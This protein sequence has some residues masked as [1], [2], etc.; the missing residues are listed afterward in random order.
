[1]VSASRPL[2]ATAADQALLVGRGDALDQV[3]NAVAAG[4]NVL[5]DSAPGGGRT[6]LVNA[7][8]FEST[9]A[10]VVRGGGA[11][12]SN[13]LA[14]CITAFSGRRAEASSGLDDLCVQFVDYLDS[15]GGDLRRRRA[16][17]GV[18]QLIIVDDAEPQALF[19]LLQ[20]L[21]DVLWDP[22]VVWLVTARTPERP[23]ILRPP[24]DAFFDV[25][26]HLDALNTTDAM[27]LLASHDRDFAHH[28]QSIADAVGGNPR[29]L[30]RAL[31]ELH[32]GQ[33]SEVLTRAT[34]Q[35]RGQVGQLSK[36]AQTLVAA[37][38]T[39]GAC[40]ASD[41]RLLKTLGWTRA[42]V[43]QV[44]SE[45]RDNDMVEQ[46]ALNQAVGRP[47]KVWRLKTP[48][49]WASDKGVA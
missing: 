46:G 20:Y 12:A 47:R 8:A 30:V 29:A 43:S 21:R 24:A 41:E 13:L 14:R 33:S 36:P 26:V 22:R 6:S 10:A 31:Q 5:V 15:G 38:E 3:R 40:S 17:P 27:R 7:V 2:R 35:H 39:L 42:R 25:R 11:D 19:D 28:H 44:L 37:L 18:P 1:M 34:T 49:E 23:V 45:L 48:A 9:V 32:T 16:E 4:L